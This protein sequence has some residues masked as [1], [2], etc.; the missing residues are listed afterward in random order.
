MY[1]RTPEQNKLLIFLGFSVKDMIRSFFAPIH[2]ISNPIKKILTKIV[3]VNYRHTCTYCYVVGLQ[4]TD[5]N[6]AVTYVIFNE[7]ERER[8]LHRNKPR[9]Q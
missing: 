5:F 1:I 4:I 8:D 9:N 2:N 3:K 7:R 6:R